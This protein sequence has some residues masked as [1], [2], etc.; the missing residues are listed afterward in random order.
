MFWKMNFIKEAGK[1]ANCFPKEKKFYSGT[2]SV[3][4]SYRLHSY[5]LFV[6]KK[7]FAKLLYGIIDWRGVSSLMNRGFFADFA[8]TCGI[9]FEFL[10]VKIAV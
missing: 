3:A 4:H 6:Y 5:P 10:T 8:Y 9:N 1:Q 2:C 7:Y